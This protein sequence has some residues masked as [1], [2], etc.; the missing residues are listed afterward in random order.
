MVSLAQT[1]GNSFGSFV[2][3]PRTGIILNHGMWRFDPS[4]GKL[5][6]IMPGKRAL[7]N[8]SPFLILRQGQLYANLGKPGRRRILTGLAQLV[9]HLLDLGLALTAALVVARF[10]CRTEEPVWLE[11]R[12]SGSLYQD[13]IDRGHQVEWH[14]QVGSDRQLIIVDQATQTLRAGVDARSD[15]SV[16]GI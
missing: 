15:A 12:A 14:Y 6:R 9:V 7:N 3:A 8:V 13:F 10:H 2:T 5:S 4:E 16:Q 11:R 1:H